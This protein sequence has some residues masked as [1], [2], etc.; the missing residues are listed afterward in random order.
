[1]GKLVYNNTTKVDIED[2]ALA[3][4]QAV[5]GAKLRR[6]ESFFF[7]WKDDPSTGNGRTSIWIHPNASVIFKYA[8]SRTPGINNAW[9]DALMSVANTPSGLRLIPE[10]GA[11]GEI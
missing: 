6:G 11:T 2:R 1:M 7:S 5:I 3:H 4:V 10:P 9:L 8:G